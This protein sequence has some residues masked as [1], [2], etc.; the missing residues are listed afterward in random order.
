M[1]SKKLLCLG[2][3][4]CFLNFVLHSEQ[5]A[6]NNKLKEQDKAA[7]DK[8][9]TSC[10]IHCYSSE[11]DDLNLDDLDDIFCETWKYHGFSHDD[12]LGEGERASDCG[13]KIICKSCGCRVFSFCITHLNRFQDLVASKLQSIKENNKNQLICSKNERTGLASEDLKSDSDR[14]EKLSDS[15]HVE[16]SKAEIKQP[17]TYWED[18]FVDIDLS[19]ADLT[20]LK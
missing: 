7:Q 10:R 1:I 18:D 11:I 15:S 14:R 16:K 20:N 12:I 4:L 2:I 8:K 6:S 5:D 13:C 9:N 19:D 3:T 17:T